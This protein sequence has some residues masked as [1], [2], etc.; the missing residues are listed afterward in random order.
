MLH[1]C[2]ESTSHTIIPLQ[3]HLSFKMHTSLLSAAVASMCIFGVSAFQDY[4]NNSTSLSTGQTAGPGKTRVPP[5]VH[6]PPP[7]PTAAPNAT[8]ASANSTLSLSPSKSSDGG[9]MKV[10]TASLTTGGA[11]SPT[12][13]GNFPTT[14]SQSESGYPQQTSVPVAG[15]DGDR[16]SLWLWQG[17]FA[18]FAAGYL[19]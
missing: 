2:P 19:V 15:N 10:S 4:G 9:H 6:V 16:V 7:H 12:A 14:A 13:A 5:A 3:P 11:Q 18:A 1:K 17:A 8:Y